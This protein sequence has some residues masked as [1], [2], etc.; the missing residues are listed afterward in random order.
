MSKFRSM[1]VM[2]DGTTNGW[3]SEGGSP[4]YALRL[5]SCAR[6]SFDELTK[7]ESVQVRDEPCRPRRK[8]YVRGVFRMKVPASMLRLTA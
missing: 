3:T 8:A 5:I 4:D 7:L 1:K 2:A 6:P